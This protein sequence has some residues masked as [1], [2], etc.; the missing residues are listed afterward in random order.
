MQVQGTLTSPPHPTSPIYPSC[1]H[2]RAHGAHKRRQTLRL[3]HEFVTSPQHPTSPIY[4][5]CIFMSTYP[6]PWGTQATTNVASAPRVR[7]IP[8]TPHL[9]YIPFMYLHVNISVPMGH[10]SDDKRCVCTKSSSDV[11]HKKWQKENEKGDLYV[12]HWIVMLAAARV[13]KI[14]WIL[15]FST[16]SRTH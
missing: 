7:H 12:S 2:I 1:Q 10:T 9:T 4:P 15:Y 16:V 5:S 6:R 8:P 13:S 14:L 11:F 3:H